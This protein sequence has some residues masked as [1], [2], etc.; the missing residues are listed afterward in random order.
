VL[1]LMQG[2]GLGLAAAAQPGPFQAYMISLALSRGWRRSLPIALAPLV[3]DAPVILLVLVVLSQVPDWFQKGLHFAGGLFILYLALHAWQSWKQFQENL[4]AEKISSKQT[5]LQA[6]LVNVLSPGPF[7]FWNLV[8][9]PILLDAW[10]HSPLQGISFLLGFY[11]TIVFSLVG[12][13][14]AFG[15][16]RKLGY[17]LNR[18]LLGISALVLTCFGFYQLWLGLVSSN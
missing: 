18:S 15:S 5:L 9:G 13:I 2:I 4:T 12:I 1:F 6:A 7:I 8:S 17:R 16:A 10:E 3:S 14:I 11:A